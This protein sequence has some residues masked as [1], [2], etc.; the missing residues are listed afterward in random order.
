MKKFITALVMASAMVTGGA[1]VAS[2][3]AI[4]RVIKNQAGEVVFRCGSI[5]RHRQAGLFTP[6]TVVINQAPVVPVA[7]LHKYPQEVQ[8]YIRACNSNHTLYAGH[9]QPMFSVGIGVTKH[10]GGGDTNLYGSQAISGSNSGATSG[11][12][13]ESR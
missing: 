7:P 11:S 4:K 2:A 12:T 3:D 9:T 5:Y 10:V 1:G 13:A 6:G 8:A